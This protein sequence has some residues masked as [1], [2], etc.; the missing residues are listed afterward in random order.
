MD[1]RVLFCAVRPTVV[2]I[3]RLSN[4]VQYAAYVGRVPRLL[5]THLTPYS[6]QPP[7]IYRTTTAPAA[8][9]IK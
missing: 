8:Q 1:M 7:L 4:V 9:I 3:H 6:H 2:F 5:A